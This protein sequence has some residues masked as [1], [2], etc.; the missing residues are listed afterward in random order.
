VVAADHVQAQVDVAGAIASGWLTDR[1]DPRRLLGG[2]YLLRGASLLVH[3]HL[4]APTTEPPM[5]AFVVFYGLDW[6]ATVPPTVA[7]C[8]DVFGLRGPIV[9]G[10]VFASHQAGAAIAAFGAGFVRDHLGAYDLAWYVSGGLCA[11]AVRCRPVGERRP[12]RN[13]PLTSCA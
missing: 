3:P 11:G 7:L 9:F 5:W 8:R 10:W 2:Y 1:I 12:P 13:M 6:V 4:L